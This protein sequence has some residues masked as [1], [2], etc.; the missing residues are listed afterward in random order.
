[1]VIGRI[2]QF[3]QNARRVHIYEIDHGLGIVIDSCQLITDLFI[4]FSYETINLDSITNSCPFLEKLII[5]MG[6][7]NSEPFPGPI[8]D[9]I[10][11]K[12]PFLKEDKLVMDLEIQSC[13]SLLI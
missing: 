4:C 10:T 12:L 9:A 6:I 1:M 5:R 2:Q 3:Y 7:F 8:V 13:G 11:S